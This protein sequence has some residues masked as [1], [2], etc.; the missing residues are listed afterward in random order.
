MSIE[1]RFVLDAN[2][3]ISA[4]LIKAGKARQALDKAQEIGIILLSESVLS[5]L[6]TV[7]SR[8]KFDKYLT[9]SERMR[10]L[11]SFVKTVQFIPVTE[12]I[13][14]CRD[15]KDD[16]YLELAVGGLAEYIVTGDNDLLVLD[17]FREIRIV[18]VNEFLTRE[19]SV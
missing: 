4:A 5:E 1:R 16:Q 11:T 2:V 18:T 10:F 12:R 6:E 19:A 8:P 7:L 9:A 15:P 14:A 3:I 17:P 13:M